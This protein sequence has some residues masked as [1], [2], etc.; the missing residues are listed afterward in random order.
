[1]SLIGI[2]PVIYFTSFLL[3]SVLFLLMNFELFPLMNNVVFFAAIGLLFGTY[4]TVF[5]LSFL[6]EWEDKKIRVLLRIPVIILLL[7]QFLKDDRVYYLL[8]LNE[9]VMLYLSYQRREINPYAARLQIKQALFVPLILIA[10][11]TKNPV[12]LILYLIITFVFKS[13]VLNAI[14]IKNIMYKKQQNMALN[15]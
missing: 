15:D 3:V 1:M 6:K 5:I 7:F 9:L 4:V 2:L 13:A 8:I 14:V 12:F 11:I 10:A